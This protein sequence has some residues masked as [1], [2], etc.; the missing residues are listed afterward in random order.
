M[1]EMHLVD[2]VYA[3]VHADRVNDIQCPGD[4]CI[5]QSIRKVPHYFFHED[6]VY[7]GYFS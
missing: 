4:R 5:L 3:Q 1:I 6:Y 7:Q 2:E